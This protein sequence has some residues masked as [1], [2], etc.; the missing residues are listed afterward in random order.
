[1]PQT[2]LSCLVLGC[3]LRVAAA[4]SPANAID[5]RPGGP[6]RSGFSALRYGIVEDP[7]DRFVML[8]QALVEQAEMAE[9]G[10]VGEHPAGLWRWR[11]RRVSGRDGCVQ[12]VVGADREKAVLLT[13]DAVCFAHVRREELVQPDP[14]RTE[15]LVLV[16]PTDVRLSPKRVFVSE[17]RKRPDPR[18][19]SGGMTDTSKT[20]AGDAARKDLRKAIKDVLGYWDD[21]V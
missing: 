19:Q 6:E 9:R 3:L 5:H 10:G 14:Y 17:I 16:Q 7:L 8:L 1:V 21:G 18:K 15:A 20:S 13:H 12:F 2:L 11:W 4:I